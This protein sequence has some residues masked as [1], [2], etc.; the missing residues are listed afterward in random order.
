MTYKCI[1]CK[2]ESNNTPQICG[3]WD[4]P[5]GI[6]GYLYTIDHKIVCLCPDCQLPEKKMCRGM[7]GEEVE[8]FTGE[9]RNVE[10][11]L[12]TQ[13]KRIAKTERELDRVWEV[14]RCLGEKER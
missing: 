12:K 7:T 5:Y 4:V 3:V 6:D 11:C 14:I 9:I 1:R 13:E 8:Y 2:R 10:E